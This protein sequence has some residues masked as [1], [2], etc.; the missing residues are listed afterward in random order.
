MSALVAILLAQTFGDPSDSVLS[1]PAR[2][3]ASVSYAALEVA[4]AD[5]TGMGTVCAC[6]AVTT[7][8]GATI[9][10]TR[11]S[12][13]MCL[14][15]GMAVAGI[16]DGDAVLCSTN[17][18]RIES[19]GVALGPLVEEART[20]TLL[21]SSALDNGAWSVASGGGA[22]NPTITANYGN[23]PD[24]TATADRLEIPGCTAGGSYSLVLQSYTGTAAAWSTSMFIKGTSGSGTVLLISLDTVLVS[25]LFVSCSYNSST[26]TWCGGPSAPLTKTFANA[27]S[28]V[29]IGCDNASGAVSGTSDT[30]A[31][32]VLVWNVQAEAGA[33]PT[34]PI[35]TTSAAAT[36]A[37]DAPTINGNALGLPGAPLSLSAYVT[38]EWS[39][40]SAPAV[41][42]IM[43]GQTGS[44]SGVG[45][46][47]IGSTIRLQTLNSGSANLTSGSQTIV[48]GNSYKVSGVNSGGTSTIYFNGSIVAGP[49]ATNSAA[50][51]WATA[52]GVG[53]APVF[54]ATLNGIISRLK[55]DS[56]ATGGL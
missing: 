25:G 5:G 40:A 49:S 3:S 47:F 28:R 17:T 30:G 13:A 39:S 9:T 16:V 34:H 21:Y 20:N 46:F 52:T 48:A 2:M 36:R 14:K 15:T 22:S 45:W 32:D 44:A 53:Y 4:P 42:G 50:Q 8:G 37:V 33:F 26:W 11:A 24:G 23:A 56:T 54:P 7:A 55:V 6:A 41:S 35:P 10:N 29:Y 12:S 1:D 27:G 51:P 18:P 38:P 43:E 19:D 31:A